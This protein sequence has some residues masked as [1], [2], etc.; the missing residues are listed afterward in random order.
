MKKT[1]TILLTVILCTSLFAGLAYAQDEITMEYDID[2]IAANITEAYGGDTDQ[3]EFIGFGVNEDGSFAIMLFFTEEDHV[4]FV[5]PAVM[6]GNM[7]SIEDAVNGLTIVFEV[8]AAD[9]EGLVLDFGDAGTGALEV[10]SIESLMEA[11]VQVLNNTSPVE[12][13]AGVE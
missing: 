8:L 6:D 4:T 1:L 12:F 5:G 3:G 10:I 7:V 9:D 13:I 2:A 11:L